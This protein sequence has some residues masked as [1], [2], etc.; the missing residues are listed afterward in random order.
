MR[1]LCHP[2]RMAPDP[3]NSASPVA[4]IEHRAGFGVDPTTSAEA[5]AAIRTDY[6]KLRKLMV[7]AGL[8]AED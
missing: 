7:S 8:K 1:I 6:E 5:V 4:A 3:A 2:G